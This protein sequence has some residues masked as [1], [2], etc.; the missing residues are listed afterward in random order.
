MVECSQEF[1]DI[2]DLFG[3]TSWENGAGETRTPPVRWATHA[4]ILQYVAELEAIRDK[5]D[6]YATC[7]PDYADEL[8]AIADADAAEFERELHEGCTI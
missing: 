8:Q 4:A 5:S 2:L 3:E 1:K 7:V 6:G